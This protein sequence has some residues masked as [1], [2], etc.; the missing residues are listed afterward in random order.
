MMSPVDGRKVMTA[1]FDGIDDSSYPTTLLRPD[2]VERIGK[3][4]VWLR[5]VLPKINMQ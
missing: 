5:C 1:V 4:S 3:D 2:T